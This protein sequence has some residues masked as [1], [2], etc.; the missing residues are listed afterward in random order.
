MSK[1]KYTNVVKLLKIGQLGTVRQ[2]LGSDG[3]EDE[4]MDDT[5]NKKSNHDLVNLYAGWHLGDGAWWD[6]FKGM[7]DKIEKLDK[8]D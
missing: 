6:D 4:S 7:F 3:P 8:D 5:I 1:G 2:R